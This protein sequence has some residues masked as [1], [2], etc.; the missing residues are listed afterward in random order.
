MEKFTKEQLAKFNG[1]NGEPTYIAYKGKVY[2]VT[3]SNLWEMGEHQGM[4]V[5]GEDLTKELADAPHEEEVFE[6]F[7]VVGE[8]I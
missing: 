6:R 7:P 1:Q 2:D 4:H 5:S 8:L 3:G